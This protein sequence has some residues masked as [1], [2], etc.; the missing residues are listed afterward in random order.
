MVHENRDDERDEL[1]KDSMEAEIMFN[2]KVIELGMNM[3][4]QCGVAD[5]KGTLLQRGPAR[6]DICINKPGPMEGG[7]RSLGS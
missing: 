5:I 2:R 4:F 1:R 6:R 7:Y 3:G